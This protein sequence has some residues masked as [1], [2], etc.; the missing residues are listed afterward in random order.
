MISFISVNRDGQCATLE[1]VV[2]VLVVLVVMVMVVDTHGLSPS[3]NFLVCYY[4]FEN[5]IA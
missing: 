4:I 5:G 2:I 1:V 3:V